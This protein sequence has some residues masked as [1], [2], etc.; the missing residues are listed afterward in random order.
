MGY[1]KILEFVIAYTLK[2]RLR[3]DNMFVFL[4]VF[5]I[6]AYIYQHWIFHLEYF[7]NNFRILLVLIDILLL[8]VFNK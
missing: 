2:K 1:E 3:V 6:D 8:K 5:S 4:L 7:A